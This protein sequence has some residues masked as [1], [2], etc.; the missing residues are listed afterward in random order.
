M[1]TQALVAMFNEKT[2]QCYTA[3]NGCEAGDLKSAGWRKRLE[4]DGCEK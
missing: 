1:C 3:K 2:G 4:A